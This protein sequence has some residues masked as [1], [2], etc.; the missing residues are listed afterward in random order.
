M[1]RLHDTATGSVRPLE[2]RDE[3]RVS[4][5]V[6]GPTV[7]DLPH[8]GHGRYALVF[9]VLRRYLLFRGLDVD[10][11]SNVTDIDDNIIKRAA[12]DGRTEADVAVEFEAE[13]WKAMDA[14]GVL[15]PTHTPHATD[16]VPQMV[17]LVADLVDRG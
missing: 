6:C 5:Y 11:V 9:D 8:L 15:R 10:F 3:G 7:Y 1:L 2:L 12:R 4:M 17:E 16:Y 14:L 13:W